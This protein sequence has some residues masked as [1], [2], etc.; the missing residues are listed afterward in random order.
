VGVVKCRARVARY[1]AGMTSRFGAWAEISPAEVNG[2]PAVP[3]ATGRA[4]ACATVSIWQGG[5]LVNT[6][7]GHTLTTTSPGGWTSGAISI[8]PPARPLSTPHHPGDLTPRDAQNF[9][10]T[11]RTMSLRDGAEGFCRA[12]RQL[13]G[14]LR[15]RYRIPPRNT[16]A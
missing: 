7:T 9:G 15:S 1:L 12:H 8:Q 6:L 5:A 3:G 13:G 16:P 2:A 4:A 11:L 14:F 10:Y